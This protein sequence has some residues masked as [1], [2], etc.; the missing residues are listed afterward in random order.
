MMAA[1]GFTQYSAVTNTDA[2]PTSFNNMQDAI[3]AEFVA[4]TTIGTVAGVISG[5][6]CTISTTAIAVAAG[7]GYGDGLKYAGGESLTFSGSDAAATYYVYWDSSEEALAKSTT[8]PDTSLDILLCKT[9]W[10]GATTHEAAALVDLRAWGIVPLPLLSCS[11][12]IGTV[13]VG[14]KAQFVC[15]PDTSLWIDGVAIVQ[16]DNGSANSTV[17]DV[18]VGASA[19]APITIFTTQA[20]RPSVGNAIT[21]WTITYS[22]IPDTRLVEAGDVVYVEVDAVGDSAQ[23]LAVTIYGRWL[24][25]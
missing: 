4:R 15:P 20:N 18:H 6:L 9:T 22:G 10:D 11:W 12:Q 21:N 17:V 8:V 5:L 2:S 24:R 14:K 19:S 25:A 3:Q 16:A 13:S 7:E 1:T 23:D